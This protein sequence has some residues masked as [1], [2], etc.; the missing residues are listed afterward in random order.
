MHRHLGAIVGKFG[1][2]Q[3]RINY[4]TGLKYAYGRIFPWKLKKVSSD[5]RKKS[6]Q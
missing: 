2:A 3:K 4:S 6:Y 5:V 1:T